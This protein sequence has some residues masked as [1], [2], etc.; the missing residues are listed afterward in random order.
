MSQYLAWTVRDR[1][2]Q[3]ASVTMPEPDPRNSLVKVRYSGLCGSDRAKLDPS[4]TAPL[5][6]PWYPGHEI[7]GI[8]ARS[9]RW[10]AVDPLVPCGICRSCGRGQIQLC[11][12]LRRIGWDL[13]GGLAEVLAVP[14]NNLVPLPPLADPAHGVLADPMAVALHGIRC[15]LAG[16]TGR[17]GIVG[18]GVLAVCTAVC[19]RAAGWETHLVVRDP[20]RAAALRSVL[21]VGLVRRAEDL[22]ACDAVIDAASGTTDQP[23]RQALSV[24]R[25]GGT[26]LVQNAY[27]PDVLLSSPLRDLFRRSVTLRGSFSYCRSN[28]R[29]DFREAVGLLASGGEWQALLTKCRYPLADLRR[30]LCDLDQPG[31]TR[32][33]RVLLTAEI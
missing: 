12:N 14:Q 2:L 17:L 23:I 4:W 1:E 28:G 33:F 7:V 5:P 16:L 27:A 10:V 18:G 24:V 32:P 30:G 11:P 29:D 3:V 21:D 9:G 26:V 6:E 15:G 19:A 8:E 25:D 22:P 31:M 13:S 20:Q